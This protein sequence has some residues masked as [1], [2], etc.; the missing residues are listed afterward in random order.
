MEYRIIS[1]D[2][3]ID[4]PWLPR[5]L[6]QTRVPTQWRE[7][8]PRVAETADGP[9]WVSGDDQWEAWGGRRGG[10]GPLSGRRSALER[11]G[12]LEPGVS[13]PTTTP[14][15]L[16]DMD[17]DGVDA[18]VMYGPIVPLLIKDPDL[19][20]VCYRAYNDWLAEFCA[21][22]PERLIGAG[23]IP[24]DDPK[25]AADEVRYLKHIGL[26]TGMFLAARV[27]LPLWDEG[28]EP[29]WEAA[30][31]TGIPIG[32]HLGGGL[33]TAV[34]SGPK[35][36]TPG[37]IG[38][39]VACA[40]VQMDEPLAA[41][42]FSGA[43]ER[44]PTLKI[45]LA[46]TG[47]GWLPYMLERMDDTYRKFCDAEAYWQ[48]HGGLPLTMPPSAYFRRQVWATFQTDHVGLRVVD[49]LGDDRVMWASDYPHPD[50]T[51]PESQKAIDDNFT[52]VPPRSARRI[53]CENAKALYGL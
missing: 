32:F 31:E 43:L 29:L 17:R 45:V 16:A 46:E 49:L 34:A 42:V 20:R 6:W 2:D 53:L 19:R 22:A 28:W 5:D 52:G 25:E 15:R 33:R 14:L 4:M 18:T 30:A 39:R 51:W 8:A 27:E 37:N 21:T 35:A 40:T 23:L 7:R 26:R 44:H 3:H 50:S 11:A 1:A 47:I 9:Y 24:I 12:V 13:R 10:V 38:V 48:M 41:V 36:A